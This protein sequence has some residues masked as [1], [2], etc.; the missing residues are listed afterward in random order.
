MPF[1]DWFQELPDSFVLYIGRTT[2]RGAMISFSVV[3]IYDDKCITRY[4]TAHGFAHRDVLGMKSG[5]IEKVLCENM[6]YQEAFDHAIRDFETNYR[7][8][9][10]FYLAR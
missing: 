7:K 6:S 9:L 10:A 3:L 4:D 1:K 2:E 8:Y 5:L